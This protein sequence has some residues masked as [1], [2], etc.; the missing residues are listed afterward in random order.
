MPAG[1]H[2]DAAQPACGHVVKYRGQTLKLT[3]GHWRFV[4]GVRRHVASTKRPEPPG[5]RWAVRGILH[6]RMDMTNSLSSQFDDVV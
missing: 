3:V 1:L 6:V 2:T 4:N 5:S